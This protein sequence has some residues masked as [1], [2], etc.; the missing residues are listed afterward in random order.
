MLQRELG[1]Q[2]AGSGCPVAWHKYSPTASP[3]RRES[4]IFHSVEKPP[5]SD[6]T[7]SARMRRWIFVLAA[8]MLPIFAQAQSAKQSRA[9]AADATFLAS[10]SDSLP[11]F[12]R[13]LPVH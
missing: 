4:G 3:G 7:R 13:M 11:R 12:A 10:L 5:Q 1:R 9:D 2:L 6:A 8:M